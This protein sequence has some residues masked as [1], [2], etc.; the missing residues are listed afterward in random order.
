MR[1]E[2]APTSRHITPDPQRRPSVIAQFRDNKIPSIGSFARDAAG[3]GGAA[4]TGGG[5]GGL[6]AHAAQAPQTMGDDG[7]I[8]MAFIPPVASFDFLPFAATNGNGVS[9]EDLAQQL[10]RAEHIFPKVNGKPL[11]GPAFSAL[12]HGQQE[13]E[14]RQD[15]PAAAHAYA[16]PLSAL[17]ES[18]TPLSPMVDGRHCQ[19]MFAFPM[20]VES[21]AS[22]RLVDD[23]ILNELFAPAA[24]QGNDDEFP[25]FK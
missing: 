24:G 5:G 2:P 22:P 10:A 4:A 15:T 11:V 3:D 6:A 1:I 18:L 23:P 16:P 20:E 25:L 21:A 19:D 12:L 13:A 8:N 17:P 7:D 14:M 9:Q